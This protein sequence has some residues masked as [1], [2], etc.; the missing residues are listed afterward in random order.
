M[1]V[2]SAVVIWLSTRQAGGPMDLFERGHW[3]GPASDMLAGRVPYRDTFPIHG[4]LADGGLDFLLFLLVRPDYALSLDL[5]HMLG[6]FLQPSLFLVAAAATR[7]PMLAA[8]GMPLYLGFATGLVADRPVIPLL[9]LAAFLWA[10]EERPRRVRAFLAGSLA[11]LGIL[12]AL[13]FGSFVLLAEAVVLLS[14]ARSSSDRPLRIGSYVLG[15][16]TAVLPFLGFLAWHSALIPFLRA[17]LLDLPLEFPKVWAGAWRFP[18]PWDLVRGW[19]TGSPYTVGGLPIGLGIAKRLYLAPT[20]GLASA[21][22]GV[23]LLRKNL[24][25][26]GFRLLAVGLA[27]LFFFRYVISRLHLEAGNALAGPTLVLMLVAAYALVRQRRERPSPGAIAG[28]ALVAIVGAVSMNAHGR[29]RQLLG[30]ALRYPERVRATAGLV[31]LTIP[32]G[33]SALVPER[34][35]QELAALLA[36]VEKRIPPGATILDLTNRPA[37]HFFLQR[38]NSTRFYDILPMQPF[39]SEVL[40]AVRAAPPAAVLRSGGLDAIDGIPNAA[41]IPRLWQLV[42]EHYAARVRVGDSVVALPSRS[43]EASKPRPHRS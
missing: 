41:R 40:R 17:S 32:R 5:H 26:L 4:F 28:L 13:D 7:Q 27:C 33:G 20:L 19:M 31:P 21:M 34:E 8:L 1:A 24:R 25:V 43:Q 10:L 6:V 18:A 29:M 37:L 14:F 3:L 12:Y 35:A 39:E 15:F 9:G 2:T 30:E 11:G 38:R 23:L 36:F 22:L 16:G 42:D